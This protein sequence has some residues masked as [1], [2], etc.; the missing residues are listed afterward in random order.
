MI[1]RQSGRPPLIVL[2]CLFDLYAMPLM[3]MMIDVAV[4]SVR[5]TPNGV[6][7]QFRTRLR[8]ALDS[9]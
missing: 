9:L 6:P 3:S 2:V 4:C 1:V 5:S 8:T 7:P